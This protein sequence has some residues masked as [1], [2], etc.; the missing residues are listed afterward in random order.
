L[1]PD[2]V[3]VLKGELTKLRRGA[4]LFAIY[5]AM[6]P[7]HTR[8]KTVNQEAWTAALGSWYLQPSGRWIPFPRLVRAI[9]KHESDDVAS[10]IQALDEI[11]RR[12][13]KLNE[14]YL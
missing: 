9:A 2:E 11:S 10:N 6:H 12:P 1:I 5:M 8:Q 4:W 3:G 14:A 7:Q 13:D